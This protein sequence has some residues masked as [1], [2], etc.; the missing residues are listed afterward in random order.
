MEGEKTQITHL[1]YH[2]EDNSLQQLQETG[3]PYFRQ[4]LF[5]RTI[6]GLQLN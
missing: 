1:A 5:F 6:L 3:V 2:R 4:I